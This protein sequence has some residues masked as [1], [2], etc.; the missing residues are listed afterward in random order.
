[1]IIIPALI[2]F[3]LYALLSF[4]ILPAIKRYRG[5]YDQ[6]MPLQSVRNNLASGTLSI[7][8]RAA[9]ILTA[10]VLPR[11]RLGLARVVRRSQ[12]QDGTDVEDD[13]YALEEGEE[14]DDFLDTAEAAD[15]LPDE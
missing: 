8:E 9:G 6:Y 10:F 15:Q 5:R 1:M 13:L 7:R 14:M 2:A 11:D 4:L 3:A 12:A